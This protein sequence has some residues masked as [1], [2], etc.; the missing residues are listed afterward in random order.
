LLTQTDA[1][2]QTRR[3]FYNALGRLF[4]RKE[5]RRSESSK[6]TAEPTA[7]WTYDD[8]MLIATSQKAIGLRISETNGLTG[9][10]QFTRSY[11]YDQFGRSAALATRLEGT[12][13]FQRNSYDQYGA[14]L[15]R[16]DAST[17][18]LLI[19][20]VM[21]SLLGSRQSTTKLL[22][23]TAVTKVYHHALAWV[24]PTRIA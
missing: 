14:V 15:Q 22:H 7:R 24:D 8:A 9:A 3:L 1:K 6:F 11:S 23:F 20:R 16:F 4:E 18:A 5:D 19:A 12:Q 21:R 10:R 13:Y 2:L 17:N